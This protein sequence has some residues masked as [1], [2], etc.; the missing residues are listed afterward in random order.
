MK[1]RVLVVDDSPQDRMVA[2]GNLEASGYEVVSL[3][4]GDEALKFLAS[5]RVDLIILDV[6]MSGMG[7]FELCKRIRTMPTLAG[8]PVM[9][10]TGSSMRTSRAIGRAVVTAWA[11]CSA[12]SPPRRTAG[13]SGSSRCSPPAQRSACAARSRS[14]QDRRGWPDA[15]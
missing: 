3:G 15:G 13:G 1:D 11:W 2:A 14:C 9:F 12:G 5:D 7:G 10:P 6:L 4:S 8:V